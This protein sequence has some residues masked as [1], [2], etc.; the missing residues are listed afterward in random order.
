MSEIDRFLTDAV[1]VHGICRTRLRDAVEEGATEIPASCEEDCEFSRWLG[2]LDPATRMSPHYF[3]VRRLHAEFHRV[4]SEVRE[5]ALAG[6]RAEA[7]ERLRAHGTLAGVS[8]A[9][10]L[11]VSAWREQLAG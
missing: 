10:T 5:M 6:R 7:L 9:L 8:E 3:V 4:A 2:A 1:T 11:E